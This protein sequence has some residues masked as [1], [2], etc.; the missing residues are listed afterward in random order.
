[1]NVFILD[2]DLERIE[3]FSAHSRRTGIPVMFAQTAADAIRVLAGGHFDMV[4]LDHDLGLTPVEDPGTGM[5]VVD[6][7]IRQS[8]ERG[9]FR[10]TQ[11]VIHSLNTLAGPAMRD[12]LERA[13]LN[14]KYRPGIWERT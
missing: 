5:Q 6:W 3:A 1:M 10:R 14:V 8:K 2:D 9:R 7:M 13:G 12:R 11:V 4:F